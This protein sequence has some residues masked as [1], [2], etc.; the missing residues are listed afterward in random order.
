LLLVGQHSFD[1]TPLSVVLFE[2]SPQLG[3][4][5]MSVGVS[6]ECAGLV[7]GALSCV[8]GEGCALQGVEEGAQPFGA[9]ALVQLHAQSWVV[10]GLVVEG[11]ASR[12]GVA[13]LALMV[14]E[15]DGALVFVFGL[16]VGLVA[17][18]FV[19]QCGGMSV[20]GEGEQALRPSEGVCGVLGSG[21][22]GLVTIC[23]VVLE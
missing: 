17:V 22:G 7:F 3:N 11:C 6:Q 21:S 1:A 10:G 15:F 19:G 2:G 4:V 16:L 23:G 8:E 18:L 9:P 13:V 5:G 20:V 14:G 12:D